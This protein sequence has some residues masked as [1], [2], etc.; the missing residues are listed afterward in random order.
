M[1]KSRKGKIQKFDAIDGGMHWS[2][3]CSNLTDDDDCECSIES[4]VTMNRDESIIFYGDIFGRI[5]SIRVRLKSFSPTHVPT[6][7]PSLSPSVTPS[8]TPSSTPS[9]TPSSS[10]P[11]PD[12]TIW[13]TLTVYS[14]FVIEIDVTVTDIPSFI[15]EATV[16]DMGN[17]L[18]DVSNEVLSG[19]FIIMEIELLIDLS[20]IR[21]QRNLIENEVLQ[22]LLKVND[23]K[24]NG[25]TI[26]EAINTI[27]AAID[28]ESDELSIKWGELDGLS[29]INVINVIQA[30]KPSDQP[31]LLP[32]EASSSNNDSVFGV[33]GT[34]GG[35]TLITAAGLFVILNI[36]LWK[37]YI[38]QNTSVK[39]QGSCQNEKR[40]KGNGSYS[41]STNSVPAVT[42]GISAI[43]SEISDDCE[44]STVMRS[45]K[46]E[47]VE[48]ESKLIV[49]YE[50]K[51]EFEVPRE[52]ISVGYAL[53]D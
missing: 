36:F 37:A 4:Q 30:L 53:V 21:Q 35:L 7:T 42:Q 20:N 23:I 47:I 39:E 17:I 22:F 10:Y 27:V 32:I 43:Y 15:P 46:Y 25:N 6:I 26:D 16:E 24:N 52:N 5:T 14:S 31:S 9:T 19:E 3:D 51:D 48:V 50:V 28:D 18:K 33:I 41:V 1:Y 40:D 13:P 8:F 34:V 29:A 49:D 12:P 44:Y 11:T 45:N 38:K 2:W